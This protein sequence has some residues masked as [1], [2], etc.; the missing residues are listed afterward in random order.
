MGLFRRKEETIDAPIAADGTL[1]ANG[2]ADDPF[3]QVHEMLASAETAQP[4]E[5]ADLHMVHAFGAPKEWRTM[6]RVRPDLIHLLAGI[7][8]RGLRNKSRFRTTLVEDYFL[9]M[10]SGEGYGS[11]QMVRV[12]SARNGMPSGPPEG[13]RGGGFMSG[14]FGG[15]KDGP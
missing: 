12:A 2:H 3:W 6:S 13:R 15:R 1:G 8:A 9:M 11:E 5:H 14:W 7:H 4:N 10:R